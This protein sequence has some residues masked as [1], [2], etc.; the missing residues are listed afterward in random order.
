MEH[1][2]YEYHRRIRYILS[3]HNK[4]IQRHSRSNGINMHSF[5]KYTVLKLL[6]LISAA[7]TIV[8]KYILMNLYHESQLGEVSTARHKLHE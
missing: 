8:T 2:Y 5:T 7:I 1:N 3:L 4:H 6:Y